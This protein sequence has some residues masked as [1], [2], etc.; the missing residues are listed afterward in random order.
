[1]KKAV[2]EILISL[3]RQLAP[4]VA[5]LLIDSVKALAS[6]IRRG[7][8]G[9]SDAE[10]NREWEVLVLVVQSTVLDVENADP[11]LPDKRAEALDRIWMYVSRTPVLKYVTKGR[12]NTLIEQAHDR[13]EEED[14]RIREGRE[15]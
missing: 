9:A 13:L 3:A 5:E 15:E 8:E 12:I 10:M 4:A 11:P 7:M 6:A 14:R 1:M 2:A